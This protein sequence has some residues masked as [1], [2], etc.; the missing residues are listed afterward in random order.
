MREFGCPERE[1]DI[2]LYGGSDS[3]RKTDVFRIG[4]RNIE[5]VERVCASR[6]L[7]CSQADTGGNFS[8]SVEVDVAAGT[9]VIQSYPLAF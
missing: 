4:A 2:R 7:A 6:K 9:V 1:I 3:A 5:A 8:R